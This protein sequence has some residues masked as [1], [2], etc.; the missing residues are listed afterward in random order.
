MILLW[1]S[2]KMSFMFKE[3]QM[4]DLMMNLEMLKSMVISTLIIELIKLYFM[5]LNELCRWRSWRGNWW[6]RRR[7]HGFIARSTHT[8]YSTS[9]CKK[10]CLATFRF[11]SVGWHW[12]PWSPPR[13]MSS[14]S[15]RIALLWQHYKFAVSLA[16]IPSWCDAARSS[17][18]ATHPTNSQ[19][20]F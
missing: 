13:S 7:S 9:T 18:D 14:L 19:T 3:K 16:T 8:Y 20:S 6:W 5:M 11:C 4:K 12:H 2:R 15:S 1:F 17:W 10:F